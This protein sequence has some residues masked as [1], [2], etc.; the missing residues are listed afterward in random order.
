MA[1]QALISHFA[2]RPVAR[3]A[4]STQLMTVISSSP[5]ST[6]ENMLSFSSHL[7]NALWNM[8]LGLFA[9]NW[10]ALPSLASVIA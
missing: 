7:G 3:K 9:H 1:T 5:P 4:F 2:L 8:T 6:I 10:L